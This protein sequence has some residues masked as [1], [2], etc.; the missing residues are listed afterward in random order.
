MTYK[1]PAGV[2]GGATTF[3]ELTDAPGTITPNTLLAGNTAGDAVVCLSGLTFDAAAGTLRLID[4][5]AKTPGDPGAFEMRADISDAA[6]AST[7]KSTAILGAYWTGTDDNYSGTIGVIV[8]DSTDASAGLRVDVNGPG[9]AATAAD[10]LVNLQKLGGVFKM[11]GFDVAATDTTARLTVDGTSYG[12]AKAIQVKI[13][14]DTHYWPLFGGADA[15]PTP[16]ASLDVVQTF[17]KAQAVAPVALTPGTTVTPDSSASNNFSL[18][19]AQDFTLANA[20]NPAASRALNIEIV[21]DGTG[22]RVWTLD[23]EYL[24]SAGADKVLSTAAGA[25]DYFSAVRNAANTAWLC[26]LTKGFA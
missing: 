20:I 15:G 14:A 1:F 21:Q 3:T 18:V 4:T 2:G 8:N 17:T 26:S 23:T 16:A 11:T 24:F 13:G 7:S 6:S 10:M 12:I 5:T 19:P 25:V 22:S 9:D